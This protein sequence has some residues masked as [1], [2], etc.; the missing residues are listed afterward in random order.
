MSVAGRGLV[1][2]MQILIDDVRD[3]FTQPIRVIVEHGLSTVP[4]AAHTLVHNLDDRAV[5]PLGLIIKRG[6]TASHVSGVLVKEVHPLVLDMQPVHV[7][8]GLGITLPP[9][10]AIRYILSAPLKRIRII[11]DYLVYKK[12]GNLP[13]FKTS[14]QLIG[15]PPAI[16]RSPRG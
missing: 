4:N 10:M 2:G 6:G 11:N 15:N 1:H 5:L 16:L 8:V 12:E 13:F 9:S 3:S 14:H 7:C